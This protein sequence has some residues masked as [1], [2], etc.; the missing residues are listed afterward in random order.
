F[1]R[2]KLRLRPIVITSTT[3][4]L[5]LFSLIFYASGQAVILQPIAISIGFGLIWGT[6]LNLMYL[7]TLYALINGIE[8]LPK[9]A[10]MLIH[11]EVLNI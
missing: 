1:K 6:F 5:G 9:N 7:P 10:K 11:E 8:P 3:T 2:A 4:F